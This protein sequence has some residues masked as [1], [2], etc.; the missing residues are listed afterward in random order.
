MY[1]FPI[2]PSQICT[3]P[4]ILLV[5]II[6]K[7]EY[8]EYQ[9]GAVKE[10][11]AQSLASTSSNLPTSMHTERMHYPEHIGTVKCSHCLRKS[12]S[13]CFPHVLFQQNPASYKASHTLL[14]A[15]LKS[16]FFTVYEVYPTIQM[17]KSVL[18]F[19]TYNQYISTRFHVNSST[20]LEVE[21]QKR[22]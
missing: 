20:Y 2:D 19:P 8:Y 9:S 17:K 1:I 7:Q 5:I 6:C 18:L 10:G 21:T 13:V 22:N 16:P 15:G 3:A 14:P 4:K 12:I 11:F